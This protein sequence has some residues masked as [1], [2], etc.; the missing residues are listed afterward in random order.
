MEFDGYLKFVFALLFVLGLIGV[1]ALLLRRFG[2]GAANIAIRRKGQDR[3]LQIVD[4]AALDARRRLV[5]VKR[6]DREHLLLLGTNSELLIESMPAKG[7]QAD[8][9]AC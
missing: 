5:L 1:L 9:T 2:P 7:A 8:K 6:D 4:I 3:R